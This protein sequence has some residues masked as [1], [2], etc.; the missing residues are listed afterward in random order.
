MTA[1]FDPATL[2]H[3]MALAGP[4][5]AAELQRRLVQDLSTVA[6]HLTQ[7]PDMPVVQAQCHVLMSLSGTVGDMSLHAM[8]DTLHQAAVDRDAARVAAL[9]PATL[10]AT[11]SLIAQIVQVTP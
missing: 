5:L 9:L 6:Q 8:A 10:L 1:P 7:G 11:Q 3:L 2:R 4:D